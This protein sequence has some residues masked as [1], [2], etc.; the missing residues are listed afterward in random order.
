MAYAEYAVKQQAFAG[1]APPQI[2]NMYEPVTGEKALNDCCGH[3]LTTIG[4]EIMY[5]ERGRTAS[6]SRPR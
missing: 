1:S 6:C 2:P 3:L 4:L 5:P